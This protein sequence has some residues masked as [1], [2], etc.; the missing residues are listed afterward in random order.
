MITERLLEVLASGG[1]KTVYQVDGMSLSFSECHDRV[2]NL[3]EALCAQ[4]AG[5]VIVYGRK[6]ISQ[7]VSILACVAAHRAYVPVDVQTPPGRLAEIVEATA[8]SLMICNEKAPVLDIECQTVSSLLAVY[9]GGSL[10]ATHENEIAYMIFTSGSTG[11]SKGVPISYKNLSHFIE[12]ITNQDALQAMK[13]CRMFS[14][15][16][17]SFD[18]SVMDLYFSIF[19]HSTIYAMSTEIRENL[20]AFFNGIR[21][22]EIAFFVLTPTL[23]QLMLLEPT[24][25]QM[26][27]PAVRG[28]FF[29]GECLEVSTVRK[30]RARFPEVRVINAYGPTEATCCVAL[31][32]ISDDMLSRPVLPVGRLSQ[33][34]AIITLEDG[35]IVLSGRS[36]FQGYLSQTTESSSLREDV[37]TFHTKDIGEVV[38]DLLYCKGRKDQQI[39]YQGYRIE[40]G[41][42]EHHLRALPGVHEA[43]VCAKFKPQSTVVKLIKAYVVADEEMQD[44]QTLKKALA[45]RVPPYMIPKTIVFM[46]TLPVN[47]NGKYDRKKLAEQ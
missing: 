42:I 35:E 15:A 5:P 33:A 11:K 4:G 36:V 40:L 26:H 7:F 13:G 44:V 46:E 16:R 3:A 8:A 1:E 19:T 38:G 43:V 45:E 27:F 34:A 39:K 18:L 6:S 30:I 41:D 14:A 17:F 9:P 47:A 24:F 28:M 29:C 22:H 2:K 31:T 37:A 12:W 10:S 25:D 32:T 20:T 23:A 21:D